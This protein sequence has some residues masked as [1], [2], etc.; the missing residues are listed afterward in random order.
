MIPGLLTYHS[1]HALSQQFRRIRNRDCSQDADWGCELPSWH[2]SLA[3]GLVGG[4]SSLQEGLSIESLLSC[5]MSA[6]VL[7][8]EHPRKN[9]VRNTSLMMQPWK[10]STVISQISCKLRVSPIRYGRRLYG[11]MTIRSWQGPLGLL[12]WPVAQVSIIKSLG[13]NHSI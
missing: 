9:K 11:G 5:H 7:Q 6:D 12:C 8:S 10:S 1:K 3:P 2:C 4:F 13:A